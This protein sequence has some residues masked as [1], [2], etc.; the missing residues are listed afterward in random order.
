MNT[1]VY[2]GNTYDRQII[3]I[4]PFQSNSMVADTLSSD[5]MEVELNIT[6]PTEIIPYQYGASVEYY[7]DNDLV[8]KFRLSKVERTAKTRYVLTCVSYVGVM[9]HITH[10]GGVYRTQLGNIM[11]EIF[12]Q[13]GMV[14]GTDYTI[15]TK[16]SNIAVAGWLPIASCRDNLQQCLFACGGSLVKD[17]AGMINIFFNAPTEYETIAPSRIYEG[18]SFEYPAKATKVTVLEHEYLK[19]S[20]DATVNL[21][22]SGSESVTQKLVTFDEPCYNIAWTGTTLVYPTDPTVGTNYAVVTGSGILTGKKYTHTTNEVVVDTGVTGDDYEVKVE[23]MTLVSNLNSK[24]CANRLASYYANAEIIGTS[25]VLDHERPMDRVY[26]TDPY[27]VQKMG[28]ISELDIQASNTVKADAKI[29]TNWQPTF[30]GNDYNFCKVFKTSDVSGGQIT[31]PADAVGKAGRFI[32]FSGFCGGQGGTAGAGGTSASQL[33]QQT[34]NFFNYGYLMG[35]TGGNG[36]NAGSGG[37]GF[38]SKQQDVNV[39]AATYN[40][41]IGAGGAGGIAYPNGYDHGADGSIGGNTSIVIDGTTVST[42][43]QPVQETAIANTLTGDVY[44]D[45]GFSGIAG[46]KGGNGGQ[47]R[48]NTVSPYSASV[49]VPPSIGWQVVYNGTMWVGG[50]VGESARYTGNVVY[51]I[52]FYGCGGSGAAYG[53]N[54]IRQTGK[55][56]FYNGN[57]GNT[58]Y[59]AIPPNGAS[60]GSPP[61]AGFAKCGNGGSGG[62]GGAGQ[63]CLY[64]FDTAGRTGTTQNLRG[65]FGGSGAQ[66]GTGSAGFILLYYN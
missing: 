14:E 51:G 66:G 13:A 53:S 33:Y 54:G 37:K 21:Y 63:E 8:G 60:A 18:G 43:G 46:G 31:I 26:I 20:Q 16:L 19:T 7:H 45:A 58:Y 59:L 64:A 50:A 9:E 47:L 35:G 32:L 62:G 61:A 3:S 25:F 12:S 34:R 6:D 56:S 17:D 11:R 30:I 22:N 41:T 10:Y 29:V 5:V 36:G 28:Y 57:T 49:I 42:E 27:G 65:S 24:N 48:V 4:N 23:N 44:G 2:N 38:R 39:L 55:G 1:I 52:N 40:V 15:E